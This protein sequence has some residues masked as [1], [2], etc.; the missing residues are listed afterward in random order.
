MLDILAA[1]SHSST[2]PHFHGGIRLLNFIAMRYIVLLLCLL[3]ANAF[4]QDMD[5]LTFK[6][7]WDMDCNHY[8]LEHLVKRDT[9][10]GTLPS[11]LL[12]P[13]VKTIYVQK[14]DYLAKEHDTVMNGYNIRYIDLDDLKTVYHELK[15]STA[16]LCY[17]S[18]LLN[19]H[20]YHDILIMPM[21]MAKK[22]KKPEYAAH[23][24]KYTFFFNYGDSR[25]G[26]DKTTCF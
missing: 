10:M 16:S 13:R 4:G 23:G 7:A 25:Y 8:L 22:N 1:L 6:G 26:Y 12:G 11:L 14:T 9:S 15:D 2:L 3:S 21:Y 20:A 19:K 18:N 17:M 5:R 24:C